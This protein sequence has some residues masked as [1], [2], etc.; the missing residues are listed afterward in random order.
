M[1]KKFTNDMTIGNP[2]KLLLRFSLPM[3]IGNLFQQLYNMAD[4]VVVGK[5]V[6]KDALA[7]VG[8]T[9]PIT[10]FIF[11]LALGLSAGISIVIS[12]YFG[13]KDEENVRKAF[14]TA[15]YTVIGASVI[16][17]IL[18]FVFSRQLLML[19]NTPDTII[20]QSVIYLRITSL[21]IV[22]I[23]AY[24]GM[25]SILRALGDSLSPL[26]FL[27]VA[28]LTNIILDLI[29]VIDFGWGVAGV[30]LATIISQFIAAVGC[31]VY[32]IKKVKILNMP[33]KEFV[34][35]KAIFKK[36]LA[37]GIPVAIQNSFVSL[38]TMAL[39]SVINGYGETIMAAATAASR[40]EQLIL[41]PGMSMGAALAAYTG[42]NIGAREIDRVKQ[43]FRASTKIILIFSVIMLP[44]VYFGGGFIM[45]LFTSAQDKEVMRIGI[46]ALRVPCF[47]YSFVGMIFVTRNLLSG[48]GDVKIPMAMGLTEVVCRVIFA[49]IL[50]MIFGYQGI[51]WAT[52]LT[53]MLTASVGVLRYFSG[54]WKNKSIISMNV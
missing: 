38:S 37:L 10:F 44:M 2:A 45:D 26:Y 17:G 22:C 30:A 28:C 33:L 19:L 27:I 6:G 52:G 39:Q 20:D 31:I 7:A 46:E 47:F 18:G 1:T 16:M 15:A 25:A 4:A 24:N 50:S 41:Q 12:Q 51:W 8:T 9:G 13:A 29:F 14:A 48:A 34:P 36:C 11:A 54:K 40:I 5:Y 3:L 43:G 35:D 21:G 42:Q 32:A 23:G 49:N 53:W